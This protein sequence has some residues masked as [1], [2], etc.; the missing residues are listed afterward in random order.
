M[1]RKTHFSAVE[2]VFSSL[3]CCP[4]NFVLVNNNLKIPAKHLPF[5]N[6]SYDEHHCNHLIIQN[7]PTS[8]PWLL[9]QICFVPYMKCKSFWLLSLRFYSRIRFPI[10]F[11]SGDEKSVTSWTL[12]LQSGHWNKLHISIIQRSLSEPWI[13][14]QWFIQF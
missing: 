1:R 9:W 14:K 11:P 10:G 5:S 2:W 8:E 6:N 12:L 3:D 7:A 13:S 4:V